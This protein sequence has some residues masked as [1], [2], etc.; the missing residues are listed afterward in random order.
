MLLKSFKSFYGILFLASFLSSVSVCQ[1]NPCVQFNEINTKIRDGLISKDDA[2][3]QV[4]DLLNRIR[5]YYVKI[6]GNTNAVDWT[7]PLE[8]YNSSAIGGKNGS[9]YILQGFD[10]FDG[11]R[12]SGHPAHDIFIHDKDQDCLDD[13]TGKPVNV[14]S[15]SN[16]IV[17]A[18]EHDWD[19]NSDLR[20]G[21]YIY[22]YDYASDGIFYY[23]HNSEIFVNTGDLVKAG[24]VIAH[25]GRTGLNAY[26]KRSPTHLHLMYMTIED[27][28]PKPKNIYNELL[29]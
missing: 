18:C 23:A 6:N 16:G 7:F 22:I 29:N 24:N 1:D 14:L 5:T 15:V 2:L 26:K 12:H 8:G 28:Y 13:F 17:I 4:R 10:Y 25:V 21:K 19:A 9:G 3:I 11:N 20:G 27:G